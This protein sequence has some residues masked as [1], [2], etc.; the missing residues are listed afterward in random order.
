M[1]GRCD[2]IDSGNGAIDLVKENLRLQKDH[3]ELPF[4]NYSLI[5]MDYSMPKMDGPT[6]SIEILK[7]YKEAN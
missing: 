2:Y 4:W 5:L 6:A 1:Q 7:L 3:P